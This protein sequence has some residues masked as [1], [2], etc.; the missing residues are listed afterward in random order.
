MFLRQVLHCLQQPLLHS[1]WQGAAATPTS[2]WATAASQLTSITAA[3]SS[4]S[5]AAPTYNCRCL[6]TDAPSTSIPDA[7]AMPWGSGVASSTSH[8]QVCLTH[9]SFFGSFISLRTAHTATGR[10]HSRLIATTEEERM[11]CSMLLARLAFGSSYNAWLAVRIF[12]IS[13][14]NMTAG[15]TFCSKSNGC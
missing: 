11:S 10:K 1:V 9:S 2:V 14:D 4:A 13:A 12:V 6:A 15:T 8:R 3:T 7:D 5:T